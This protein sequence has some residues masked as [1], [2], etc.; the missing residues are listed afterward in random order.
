M[1]QLILDKNS[2]ACQ[3][4]ETVLDTLLRKNVDISYSCKKGT[5]HSCIVRSTDIAPPAASQNGLKDTL[6]QQN[7]FLACCCVPE[8]DMS[9]KL[10]EQSELFSE[11]VVVAHEMLNRNTLLLTVKHQDAIEYKPGQFVNLQKEGGVTRSYSISNIPQQ[12]GTLEF[13]IRK[14]PGGQF[15]EWA[16]DTL[17]IGDMLPISDAQGHC[18][19][20]PERKEQSM[21][22]IGT[23]TGLAPL[24]GILADALSQGHLGPI[25]LFH[26]SSTVEDLYRVNEMHQLAKE[27]SNFHYTPCVSTGTAPEGFNAGRAHEVALSAITDFSGWRVFLCGHPDMVNQMKTESFL[28]GASIADIYTDAFH[29][30]S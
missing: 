7:Y 15:S 29:V 1:T 13:H 20:L 30:S 25:H 3:A 12:P 22:L 23:G 27:H 10:P 26:G 14:I 8:K 4:Q 5:C 6:K 24:V 16:H 21:V 2:Y 17:K 19:Y 18:F 11:C 9:I 28:K